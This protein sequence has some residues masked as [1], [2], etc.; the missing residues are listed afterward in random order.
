MGVDVK[1]SVY[2]LGPSYFRWSGYIEDPNFG[3][4]EIVSM[5]EGMRWVKV[6]ARWWNYREIK[7]LILS[8]CKGKIDFV[9][10][11]GATLGAPVAK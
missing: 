8:Q 3:D 6:K 4:P 11:P 1:E 9:K 2:A 10:K 7:T 5:S